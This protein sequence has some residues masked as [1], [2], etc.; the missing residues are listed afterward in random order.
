MRRL[1]AILA[2]R[3]W[4]RK[5]IV[6]GS[7][8][9]YRWV[10]TGCFNGLGRNLGSR[11]SFEQLLINGFQALSDV[12]PGQ[13]AGRDGKIRGALIKFFQVPRHCLRGSYG[14]VSRILT[15]RH[16]CPRQVTKQQRAG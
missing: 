3:G 5:L 12:E 8:K 7:M 2:L 9:Y 14:A 6:P 16:S 11:G 10:T 4:L 15:E 1:A 13:W